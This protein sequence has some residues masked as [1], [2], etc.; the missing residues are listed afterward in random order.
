[1]T[2]HGNALDMCV[3]AWCKLFGG[4]ND[5]HAWQ[6]VVSDSA[7]F[8]S[9][10]LKDLGVSA[11]EFDKFREA[12]F[13]YRDKF[14]AH[15]DFLRIMSIPKFELAQNSVNFYCAY[16]AEHEAQAGDLHGLP[17]SALKLKLGFEQCES[18]AATVYCRLKAEV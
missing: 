4:S 17:D 1:M 2:V 7:A 5:Q 3:L 18:E 12:M 13:E 15:L 9:T 10:L 14:V 11:V 16:V 6:K 8:E